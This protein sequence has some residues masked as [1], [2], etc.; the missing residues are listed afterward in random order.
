[1]PVSMAISTISLMGYVGFLLG[2]P[3]IGFI[4]NALN[5]RWAFLTCFFFSILIGFFVNK[6]QN[7]APR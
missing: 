3:L 2:P 5:L 6:Y 7:M 4:S 1:V